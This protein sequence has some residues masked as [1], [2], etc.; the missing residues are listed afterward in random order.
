MFSTIVSAGL[1]AGAFVPS[2]ATAADSA[3]AFPLVELRQYTLHPG[4][5]D[6]LIDLFDREFVESQEAVGMKVI[7]QYRDL[8]HEDRFVWLRGFR[9]MESRAA[10]LN[11]F[12]FGPVWQAHREAANATI[13]DSDNVL[14]LRAPS[15]GAAFGAQP[16][17]AP[18]G[19]APP[20]GGL[21]VAT[22]YHL[23]GEPREAAIFFVAEIAPRLREAGIPVLAY[24]VRETEANNFPRLPV[25]EN[26][27]VLVW[28]SRFDSAAEH[29]RKSADLAASVRWA[30][31]TPRLDAML[32]RPPEI[33][34]LAPTARSE[35]R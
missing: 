18:V 10:G 32:A 9:D 20:S 14:L 15:A 21:I 4:Q 26:E 17:R 13:V 5:R 24:F 2:P 16:A 25:R 6:T 31:I 35:L 28:F 11:A 22:L 7:G 34:R 29:Q 19:V 23:R 3:P 30:E 1:A 8:D 27:R 33:L 12:Y